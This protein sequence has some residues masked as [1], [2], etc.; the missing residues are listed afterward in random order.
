MNVLIQNIKNDGSV[1]LE[2]NSI[3]ELIIIKQPFLF[4][5]LEGDLVKIKITNNKEY[6]IKQAKVSRIIRRKSN[7]F[8]ARLKIKNKIKYA[9][10]Y[11]YQSKEIILKDNIKNLKENDVIDIKVINWNNYTLPADGKIIKLVNKSTDFKADYNFIIGKYK[12]NETSKY[13]LDN[14]DFKELFNNQRDSRKDLKDL[15][16]FTI[17]PSDAKDYDDAISI[18]Y[19]NNTYTLYIHIADVSEFIKKDDMADLNAQKKGNSYYFPEK[20]IHMLPNNIATNLCSL[21]ALESRLTLTLKISISKIG[22][23]I[24]YQFTESYIKCK[25]NFSY[26]EVDNIINGKLKSP[27]KSALINLYNLSHILKENRL[28]KGGIELHSKNIQ[29]KLNNFGIPIKI[30]FKRKYKSH[31][32]IEESMLLANRIA[33]AELS[34]LTDFNSEFS[35]FRNHDIPSKKSVDFITHLIHDF[36]QYGSEIDGLFKFSKLNTILNRLESKEKKYI[37]SHLILRKL[38][39]ARYEISNRGHFGTGFGQYTHFTSPIRRY[40]DLIVHRILKQKFNSQ[41]LYRNEELMDIVKFCNDGENKAQAAERDYYYLKG[42]KWIKDKIKLKGIIFGFTE[43]SI[44]VAESQTFLIGYIKYNTIKK[45]VFKISKNKLKLT[46]SNGKVTLKVGQKINLII[47]SILTHSMEIY[48]Q[49]DDKH[50]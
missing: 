40:S 47:N 25:K 30:K 27:Y 1:F 32:M 28:S 45:D 24:D 14:S 8:R 17:D 41:K 20:V 31:M 3:N 22:K 44:K 6:W 42:L 39:K 36:Q 19:K 46:S 2:S 34:N 16:T 26:R 10:I 23:V 29:F 50:F 33:A 21:I 7:H 49:I 18:L 11:P 5:A 38:R 12:L 35:I 48:F 13:Q 37:L 15:E 43:K 4:G 9:I